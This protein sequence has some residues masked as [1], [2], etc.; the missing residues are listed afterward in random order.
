MIR[1]QEGIYGSVTVGVGGRCGGGRFMGLLSVAA[2]CFV[3]IA[4]SMR[5]VRCVRLT[6]PILCRVSLGML[7]AALSQL[8]YN[9]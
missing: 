3:F 8:L 4:A 2:P 5:N 1:L 6:V 9:M 7:L